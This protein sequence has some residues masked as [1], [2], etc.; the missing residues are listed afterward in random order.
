MSYLD[1][2]LGRDYNQTFEHKFGSNRNLTSGTQTIW[3]QGG[4]Y[5]WSALDNPQILYIISTSTSDTGTLQV[6]GL[7]ADYLPLSETVTLTGQTAKATQNQFKRVFRMISNTTNVGVITARTISGAGTVVAHMEA[8]TSQ[9]LMAVYTIPA[10]FNAYGTQFTVGVGKG[11]DATFKPYVR[12]LG[13][14]FRIRGEVELYQNTFTQTYTV[15]IPIGP[16]ADI[17]FRAS[18]TAN[19]FPATAS[20]DLIL[21]KR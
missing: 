18:A 4:L 13:G 2:A 12:E 20:F 17:D 3:T 1:I 15:P 19:N 7:D 6:Y 14:A 5:P 11:G 21:Y 10:T 16:K 9:T 8:E